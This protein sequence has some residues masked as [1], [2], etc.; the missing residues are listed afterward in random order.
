MDRLKILHVSII[1]WKLVKQ[2]YRKVIEKG[3]PVN[4]LLILQCI[5]DGTSA[6]RFMTKGSQ[7]VRSGADFSLGVVILL[8]DLIL[9]LPHVRNV[10][11]PL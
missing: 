4:F 10:E 8:L 1:E 6:I 2:S 11:D 9:N 3:K 7:K 5:V